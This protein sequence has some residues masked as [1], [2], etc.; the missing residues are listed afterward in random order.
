MIVLFDVA[1]LK[2]QICTLMASLN[3]DCDKVPAP[4]TEIV[5]ALIKNLSL[6]STDIICSGNRIGEH[7][8]TGQTRKIILVPDPESCFR[9]S[10]TSGPLLIKGFSNLYQI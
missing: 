4:S 2:I 6:A 10:E 9:S 1:F 5:V 8:T 3:C 7:K